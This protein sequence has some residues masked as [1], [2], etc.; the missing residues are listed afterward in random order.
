M[1]LRRIVREATGQD[2]IRCRGCGDCDRPVEDWQD[3][4]LSA[5]IQLVAMNDEEVLS[6][7]TLW[8]D[9]A[10]AAAPGVCRRGLNLHAVLLALRAEASKRN[11]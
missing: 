4:S 6:S 1:S 10:L 7:R 9:Q 8:A 11:G 3:L 5:I 2:V